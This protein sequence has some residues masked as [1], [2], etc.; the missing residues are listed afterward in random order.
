MTPCKIISKTNNQSILIVCLS[1]FKKYFSHSVHTEMSCYFIVCTHTAY[2][3][4][5]FVFYF[6]YLSFICQ[7]I[8]F[9]FS[10]L[11]FIKCP[12]ISLIIWYILYM[13]CTIA[14]QY[15]FKVYINWNAEV[16][17]WCTDRILNFGLT[18]YKI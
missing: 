10:N 5:V 11:N 8:H 14:M 12:L 17:P 9:I 15:N 3:I 6:I 7:A 4:H 13:K 16:K 18:T 2:G 1:K